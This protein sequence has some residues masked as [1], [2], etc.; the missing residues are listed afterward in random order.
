MLEEEVTKLM[1]N[2]TVFELKVIDAQ[3]KERDAKSIQKEADEGEDDVAIEDQPEPEDHP[4]VEGHHPTAEDHL[5]K[6]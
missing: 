2:L 5:T 3:Q 1:A 6:D 4:S